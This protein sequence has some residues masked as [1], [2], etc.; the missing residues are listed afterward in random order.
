VLIAVFFAADHLGPSLRHCACIFGS[1]GTIATELVKPVAEIDVIT[2]K[3]PFGQDSSNVGSEHAS[4]FGGRIDHHA[5]QSR[6]QRQVPQSAALIGD[7]T[8]TI[9]CR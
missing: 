9:D 8:I 7:A 4:A 5:G 2:T 6:R 1:T 3:T